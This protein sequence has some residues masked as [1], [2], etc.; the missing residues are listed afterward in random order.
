[1]YLCVQQVWQQKKLHVNPYIIDNLLILDSNA[2]FVTKWQKV[3]TII[4]VVNEN[5]TVTLSSTLLYETGV[6][7][8]S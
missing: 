3:L 7:Q 2:I 8:T 1:M 4:S 5:Y 6:I